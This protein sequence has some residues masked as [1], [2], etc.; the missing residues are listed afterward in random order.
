MKALATILIAIVIACTSLADAHA[1]GGIGTYKLKSVVTAEEFVRETKVVA[2]AL[3]FTFL[4]AN[5]MR[6]H[7]TTVTLRRGTT[8][9]T[10]SFL[11]FN[12]SVTL[13]LQPDGQTVDINVRTNGNVE[14]AG[15]P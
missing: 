4:G 10:L 11:V 5:N 9:V 2:Q 7:G 13:S 1:D 14:R 15:N 12:V 6:A 3:D 8:G